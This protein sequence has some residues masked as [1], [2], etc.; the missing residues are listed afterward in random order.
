M[1]YGMTLLFLLLLG[2]DR[3]R[4]EECIALM[5]LR[6]AGPLSFFFF[7]FS[8]EYG[9]DR[10]AVGRGNCSVA[11]PLPIT[12]FFLGGWV[13][14]EKSIMSWTAERFFFFSFSAPGRMR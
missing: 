4:K 7:F 11:V 10:D 6:L 13:V 3:G 1:D 14:I 8:A 9:T 2:R 12:F 5:Q